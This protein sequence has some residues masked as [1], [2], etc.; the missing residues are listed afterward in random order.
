MTTLPIMLVA[1]CVGYFNYN[2]WGKHLENTIARPDDSRPTPA[3]SKRDNVDFAPQNKFVL[4]GSH[5]PAIAGAGPITGPAFAALW[6][7]LPGVLYL[8][9]GSAVLGTVHDYFAMMGSVR[10]GGETFGEYTRHILGAHARD[11]IQIF[12][13]VYMI[14]ASAAFINTAAGSFAG[15][16]QAVP[17]ALVSIPVAMITGYLLYKKKANP[18]PVTIVALAIIIGS[19]YYGFTMPPIVM[20]LTTWRVVLLIYVL[21][22]SGLPVWSL[23]VPRG[24]LN[25][26]ILLAGLI[27]GVVSLLKCNLPL[28]L[29]AFYGFTSMHG[30]P[31]WPMLFVF[32][33][34][35]AISGGHALLGTGPTSKQIDKETD[36]R[37]V[38]VGAF[39]LE[40]II[41]ITAILSIA[42]GTDSK[43]L[44]ETMTTT[45]PAP[46]FGKGFGVVVNAAFPSIPVELGTVIAMVWFNAF[47]MTTAE[48]LPRTGRCIFQELIPDKS[49]YSWFKSVVGATVCSTIIIAMLTFSSTVLEA[50]GNWLLA[51]HL[52]G[53]AALMILSTL[54][55]AWRG[56]PKLAFIP[57]CALWLTTAVGGVYQVKDYIA[58]GKWPIAIFSIVYIILSV[59]VFKEV[60]K[61]LRKPDAIV[62]RVEKQ[63]SSF[64]A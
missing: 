58:G 56:N 8:L 42:A 46:V 47:V 24:Y 57:G 23:L 21:F 52:L 49:Q 43:F 53:G 20:S 38:A 50:L 12:A 61:G 1:L 34:C 48:S 64:T 2:V 3:H 30:M 59:L 37:F 17:C 51:D 5:W 54:I 40:M 16:P 62:E 63:T 9:V 18:V 15:V 26:Y 32:L 4:L 35:G 29:P 25:L 19:I 60:L 39:A 36:V 41:A 6:G 44:L 31:L 22:A 27:L 45:G 33:G 55:L 13:F 14:G 10:F 28:T 11:I 7:W